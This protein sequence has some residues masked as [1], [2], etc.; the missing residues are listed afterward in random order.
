MSTG[1]SCCLCNWVLGRVCMRNSVCVDGTCVDAQPSVCV[2]ESWSEGV[3]VCEVLYYPHV[4]V[5]GHV[6]V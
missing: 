1:P 6:C 3:S 2:S 4:S 5:H